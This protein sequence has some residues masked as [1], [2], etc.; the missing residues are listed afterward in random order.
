MTGYVLV[1]YV[2]SGQVLALDTYRTKDQCVQAALSSGVRPVDA[3][4][5][6][7]RFLC[8]PRAGELSK[9]Q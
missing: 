5:T 6:T 7:I 8:V 9:E 3:N 2:L 4:F 1:I